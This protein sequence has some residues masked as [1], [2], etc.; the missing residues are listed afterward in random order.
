MTVSINSQVARFL[1][2]KKFCFGPKIQ[3]RASLTAGCHRLGGGHSFEIFCGVFIAIVGGAACV[4]CPTTFAEYEI[5]VNDVAGRANLAARKPTV[6]DD[7][8]TSSKWSFVVELPLD[9]RHCCVQHGLGKSSTGHSSDVQVLDADPPEPLH[10]TRRELVRQVLADVGDSL[11]QSSEFHLGFLP[12]LTS[13]GSPSQLLV[14]LAQLRFV[15]AQDTGRFD[16]LSVGEHGEIDDSSIDSHYGLGFAAVGVGPSGFIDFDLNRD[17]PV[18]CTLGESS[19]KNLAG[20]A[21][22]LAH[23]HPTELGDLDL[24]SLEFEGSSFNGKRRRGPLLRLEPRVATLRPA[25]LRAAEEVRKSVTKV[26]ECVVR[27]CP[28]KR[29]QPWKLGLFPRVEFG[30][31]FAPV[32]L[33]AA[34]VQRLPASESPVE[35]EPSCSSAS[36]QPRRLDVVWIEPDAVGKNDHVLV[37]CIS[38]SMASRTTAATEMSRRRASSRSQVSMGGVNCI[39]C[40][41]SFS[42][43][44]GIGTGVKVQYGNVPVK[45]Q[46]QQLLVNNQEDVEIIGEPVVRLKT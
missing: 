46:P 36:L 40:R 14:D 16:L 26:S 45:V 15:P 12:V 11:M 1:P 42:L 34:L 28:R 2:M 7:D 25:E 4:A 10:E 20:E 21:K 43:L 24:A 23:P 3:A 8:Y 18:F 9:F 33:L 17:V 37:D 41:T 39:S 22:R 44:R 19:R 5:G 29:D 30:V 13:F 27:N 31:E 6:S 38:R 32:G 35:N